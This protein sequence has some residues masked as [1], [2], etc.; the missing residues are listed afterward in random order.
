MFF[1]GGMTTIVGSTPQPAA[2]EAFMTL[3]IMDS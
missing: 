2:N 3:K 1:A